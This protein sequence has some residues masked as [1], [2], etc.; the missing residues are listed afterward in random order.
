M[1]TR[2]RFGAIFFFVAGIVLLVAS[3]L[4]IFLL[5]NR[6]PVYTPDTAPSASSSRP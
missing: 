2:N 5:A 6:T 3:V 1:V 4:G